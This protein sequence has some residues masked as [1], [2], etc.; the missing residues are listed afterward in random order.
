MK[1]GIVL[2]SVLLLLLPTITKAQQ[3]P[4]GSFFQ[5]NLEEMEVRDSLGAILPTQLVRQLLST[6]KFTVKIAK[7]HTTGILLPVSEEAYQARIQS[8][9]KPPESRFFVN[10]KTISS[11][12]EKDMEGKRFKLKDQIGKV[13]VLN[14]WFINCPPCQ[15]EIPQLN[16][17]VDSYAGNPDVVFL[18][19]ALD[20][21]YDIADFLKTH[22]FK[23]RIID[24]GRY[25]ANG[26]GINLFPTHVVLDREGKVL[27]HTSGLALNTVS[28]IK[29]S[30]EAGLG[31][32]L[33]Q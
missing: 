24:G 18:S 10:G 2:V 31:K 29:K 8:M 15:M 23:Y 3:P 27:F 17:L 5:L 25:I 11:I 9:P 26:F 22:P 30:I 32:T 6:G 7:D 33:S 14:F 20:E 13:V 28:W 12:N 19:V 4:K 16:T 21:R 1:K